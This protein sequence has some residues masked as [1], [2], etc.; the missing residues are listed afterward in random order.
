MISRSQPGGELDVPS[1]TR[2]CQWQWVN[3]GGDTQALGHGTHLGALSAVKSSLPYL[4][5]TG[6]IQLHSP[7]SLVTLASVQRED[8]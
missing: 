4:G 2:A 8:Q 1:S 5:P 3:A 6:D 7:V